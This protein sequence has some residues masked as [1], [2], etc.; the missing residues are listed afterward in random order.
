MLAGC[1]AYRTENG[2]PCERADEMLAELDRHFDEAS[3][4]RRQTVE[5]VVGQGVKRFAGA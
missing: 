2:V 3:C 4:A 5:D 1:D